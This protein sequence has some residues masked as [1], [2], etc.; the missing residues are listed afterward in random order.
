ME[1][2]ANKGKVSG[3]NLHDKLVLDLELVLEIQ[4]SLESDLT[5]F[6]IYYFKHNTILIMLLLL[7]IF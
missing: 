1:T 2:N 3:Q 7:T 5:D 4:I 6:N